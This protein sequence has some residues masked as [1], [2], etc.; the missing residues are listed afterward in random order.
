MYLNFTPIQQALQ[1]GDLELLTA[2]KQVETDYLLKELNESDLE[3]FKT[4]NFISEVKLKKKGDHPYTTLRASDILKKL[5]ISISFEGAPDEESKKIGEWIFSVF[6]NRSGG[7]IK[8]KTETI[9]RLHWFKSITRIEGN[10]L[11]LLIQSYF[12]DTYDA[13]SGVS[14]KDFME[15]N[16]R[17]VLNQMCDNICWSPPNHFARNYTLADSPLYRYYEDNQQYI[18]NIWKTNLDED[19]NRRK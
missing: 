1:R 2:I 7:I 17:G 6:K 11:A 19:G 8:N 4:L 3:R 13:N 18:E 15:E 5:L 12:S 9:R 14:V 10:F 16:K